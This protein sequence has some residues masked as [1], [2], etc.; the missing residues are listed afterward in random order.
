MVRASLTIAIVLLSLIG[1][2]G[3]QEP[4][5]AASDPFQLSTVETQTTIK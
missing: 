5:A 1:D 4:D 2:F 3:A